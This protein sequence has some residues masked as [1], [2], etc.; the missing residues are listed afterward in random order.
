MIKAKEVQ[1]QL[2]YVWSQL[3]FVEFCK[4]L[5]LECNWDDPYNR[6]LWS[7]F[8]MMVNGTCRFKSEDLQ[9]I[10]EFLGE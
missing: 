3:T 5:K 7:H 6:E 9:K 4:L 1:E 8:R 10:L 2:Q